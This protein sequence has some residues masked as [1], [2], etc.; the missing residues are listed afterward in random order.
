M[1]RPVVSSFS[2]LLGLLAKPRP[3]PPAAGAGWAR[4]GRLLL[5]AG[6]LAAPLGLSWAQGYGSP[7]APPPAAAPAPD[8]APSASSAIDAALARR[9]D[10]DTLLSLSAEGRALYERDTVQLDGYAYCGQ[11]VALAEKGHLRQS[12]Q[13]AAKALHVGQES[14]DP[15][16]IALAQR[17]LA[18]A[19]SYAGLLD[20]AERYARGAL[21]QPKPD[22]QQ[23]QAPAYKVL[24]DIQARRGNPAAAIALY[25]QSLKHASE[26][27]RPLVLVSL[28]NAQNASGQPRQ[29]LEQLALV[30]EPARQDMGAYFLRTKAN[31]LRATG[32]PEE[33]LALY[34]Q[35]A[36]DT[37]SPDADYQRLWAWAGI[38]R[39]QLAAGRKADALAAY[40]Q[41][42]TLADGLRARFHSD[43]FRTG[44]FGDLQKIFDEALALA[45]EQ[46]DYAA[47]WTLSEGSRSRQLL[48]AIRDRATD[49]LS[50]RVSL[51]DLQKRL[52]P[53][54]AVLQFHAIGDQLVAWN[55]RRDA[56]IG[57]TL[58]LPQAELIAE[59]EAFRK[60]V[61]ERKRDVET[62]AQALH[63]KLIAPLALADA[64]Q[65]L[66]IV[67]HGP[68]H[69]LP[70]QALH[71]G[72][73]YLIARAGLAVW[74]SASV[75]AQLWTRVQQ[76]PRALLA[77]GNPATNENVPLPGAERE[78]K[79]LAELFPKKQVFLQQQ[80]TK[81]AF[82]SRAHQASVLHVAAHAE[83]D[84]VDPLFSRILFAAEGSDRGLLEARDIY[85]L[86]L[87]GVVMVTL[88]AC[89]SGLGKIARGEEIVGFT[90]SFLSAGASSIIASLWPV[91]DDS[92]EA[93]MTRL[94]RELVEGRDLMSAMQAAQID[95]Q[96]SRRFAHP[97]FWAPF[98][99]IGN[100]RMQLGS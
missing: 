70:F 62:R 83:V 76:P 91:A 10:A 29:A 35:V 58:S 66:F 19:Y 54:E 45:V 44:L 53:N 71:D 82:K 74:P 14:K 99:V 26:R 22:P 27:F 11:S 94:Y 90:R 5:T 95:V 15:N 49:T 6:V 24:G 92:T 63:A 20:E 47:A 39:V 93:L 32:Q 31:S 88:S 2:P 13:A 52:A 25:N 12:I 38:A 37:Q 69:Y 28:A 50:Q 78:V 51:A 30:D 55:I 79:G 8:A 89:E 60:S 67:P 75:G 96:K 72:E 81:S 68:L 65:R 84:E 17:D 64:S 61:I 97:F 98:N 34:R 36:A 85:Q 87:K 43:E 48:D 18:I 41:A 100:G 56:F 80:A 3:H 77:F 59:V 86:D 73:R 7:P 21:E 16:L 1:S 40:L 46:Q 33:A 4:F 23:V 9:R 42:T 57:K